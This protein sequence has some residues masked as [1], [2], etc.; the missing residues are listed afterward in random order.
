LIALRS[1]AFRQTV[2]QALSSWFVIGC[3]SAEYSSEPEL[4]E[5][6]WRGTDRGGGWQS[7]LLGEGKEGDNL[8][9]ACKYL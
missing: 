4:F 5:G 9:I 1:G 8:R 7:K 2:A 3:N 6:D